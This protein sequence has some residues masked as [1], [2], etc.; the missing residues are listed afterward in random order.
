MNNLSNPAHKG[1]VWHDVPLPGLHNCLTWQFN[2]TTHPMLGT[3]K[4]VSILRDPDDKVEL[5]RAG[6]DGLLQLEPGFYAARLTL[7]TALAALRELA[8]CPETDNWLA[9]LDPA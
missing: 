4:Y 1:R 5:A 6:S 9:S 8:G 2:L 7:G 3:V